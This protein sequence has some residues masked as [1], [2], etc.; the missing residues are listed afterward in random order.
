MS[1]VKNYQK[2]LLHIY[3]NLYSSRLLPIEARVKPVKKLVNYF[4]KN[5]TEEVEKENKE[6]LEAQQLLYETLSEAMHFESSYNLLYAAF[7]K[8]R[9][10]LRHDPEQFGGFG[11][12]LEQI[13]CKSP[14][15]SIIYLLSKDEA[16]VDFLVRLYL[17][18]H[19][20]ILHPEVL[21]NNRKMFDDLDF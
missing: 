11:D 8:A 4:K 18:E 17:A 14:E 10:Q 13:P 9:D 12:L 19:N 20:A 7:S 21:R 1:D 2:H 6:V 16:S 15:E 5:L 3:Q